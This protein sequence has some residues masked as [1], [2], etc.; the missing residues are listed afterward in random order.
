MLPLLTDHYKSVRF[1]SDKKLP[2]ES[3]QRTHQLIDLTESIK[4]S[5]NA[6]RLIKKSQKHFTYKPIFEVDEL[7]GIIQSTLSGKIKEFTPKNI[8]KLKALMIAARD[9][10]KGEC[11]GIFDAGQ[12]VG[13]GFFFKDKTRITYLKGTS[14]EEAKKNGAMFGL[15]DFAINKFKDQYKTFDFGGSDIDNVATFY[16]KFGAVDKFYFEYTINHLP[17][18]FKTLKKIKKHV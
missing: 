10:N 2:L 8:D 7:I 1:R 3:T 15:I 5:T 18:W 17:L 6:K 13:G 9:H 4:Y 16:K 11:I 14:T 12:L